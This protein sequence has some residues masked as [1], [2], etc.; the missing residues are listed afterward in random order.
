[1]KVGYRKP[2]LKKSIKARTTGKVKRKIKKSVNPFYGKKGMGYVKNPKRAIKNKMYHKTTFGTTDVIRAASAKR[3]NNTVNAPD[4]SSTYA[5]EMN[6]IPNF[7]IVFF[8][9]MLGIHKFIEGSAG[10]GV[11]YLFT[12][13]LFGIGWLIDVIKALTLLI[14]SGNSSNKDRLLQLQKIV[15]PDA[16]DHLVMT[17]QQLQSI[18]HQQANDDIRIIQDSSKIIPT[19]TNPDVFFSRLDLLKKHT[20]HLQLLEPFVSLTVSPTT[21][22][23]ELLSNEQQIIR[24]FI[25]RYFNSVQNHAK[26]L[27]TDKG[28]FN[29]YKKFYD[30]MLNYKNLMSPEIYSFVEQLFNQATAQLSVQT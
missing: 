5:P 10:M 28:K 2:N 26:T 20:Y 7:C 29:Q 6:P 22:M 8:L 23:N 21:V 30:T 14:E 17:K 4:S 11:L 19:T 25:V 13:G 1:M 27:K 15:M 24:D 3:T 18:A 9:G 12:F 16:P